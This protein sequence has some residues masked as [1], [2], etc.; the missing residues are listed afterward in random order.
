MENKEKTTA[1]LTQ[2]FIKNNPDIKNCLKK[3]LLNYSALARLIG[4]ELKI[5]KKSSKEAI[6]VAAIRYQQKLKHEISHEQ[7]I[8][9]LLSSAEIE[10]KNKIALFI[11]DK[12]V[13]N[14][15]LQESLE[16]IRK[17]QGKTYFLEGSESVMIIF[18]EKYSSSLKQKFKS[19][20]IS[21][22]NG[23]AMIDFKTTEK[24]EQTM[25][26]VSYLTSL[27]R[28]HG[29]NII[30]FLSCWTDTWFIIQAK[31]TSKVMEFLKF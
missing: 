16:E 5:D 3:G 11:L 21:E 4:K 25:G 29:V 26:V 23:L 14:E 6:L 19:K 1:E 8:R 15:L 12:T 28:E 13:S 2:E 7:K 22:K 20:I 30:E 9:E 27:F 17:K 10:I 24:I 31:D 18:P